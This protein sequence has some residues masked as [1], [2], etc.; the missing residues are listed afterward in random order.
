MRFKSILL[1]T[2]SLHNERSAL[3][4][5]KTHNI[6]TEDGFIVCRPVNPSKPVLVYSYGHLCEGVMLELGMPSLVEAKPEPAPASTTEPTAEH[7]TE[8]PTQQPAHIAAKP[9]LSSTPAP[10]PT[11]YQVRAHSGRSSKR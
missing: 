1:R 11:S 10:V 3:I 4:T 5:D 7:P 9:P 8:P 2:P 6:E